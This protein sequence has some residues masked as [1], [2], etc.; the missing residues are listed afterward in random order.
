MWKAL[1]RWAK[2]RHPQKGNKWIKQRYFHFVGKRNWIFAA[3][4]GENSRMDVF[5]YTLCERWQLFRSHGIV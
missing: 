5:L 3:S 2:R 4:T 1:W